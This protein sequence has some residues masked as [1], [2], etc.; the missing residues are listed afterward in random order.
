M[1]SRFSAANSNMKKLTIGMATFDDFEGV[2]FTIQSIRLNNLPRLDDLDLVVIDNN[3]DSA[4]GKETANFCGKANVRYF[5]ERE[6]RS[7]AIRDRVFRE[8]ESDFALCVDPH[9]LL[10]PGAIRR[11]I[12][13]AEEHPETSDLFH[14]PM[15]YDYL[16]EE[17]PATHMD[18]VWR[19]NMYGIWGHDKRGKEADADPFEIEMHGLGLFFC[20]VL[21]WQ[22]FSPLFRGFGGEEGYI[23]RKFRQ[24]GKT[25][26]LLPWL[27]WV[28]RFQRPRGISYPLLME[29]RIQNYFI[30]WE[31]L[32]QDPQEIHDHFA[33][34][35]PHIDRD[36]LQR[37]AKKLL[38]DLAKD[39]DETIRKRF[40]VVV[41]FKEK[42]TKVKEK[43]VR[44]KD[45]N[46]I[47]E[48]WN[49]TKVELGEA[50]S[51]NLPEDRLIVKSFEVSWSRRPLEEDDVSR[52]P[53]RGTCESSPPLG[54]RGD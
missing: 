19:D 51:I 14:G 16:G 34:T 3:P 22:G 21:A 26:L 12:E 20:R 28:H 44:K 47:V 11:L 6:R 1:N 48:L 13:F 43:E 54:P 4:E 36:R 10:E 52:G 25:V 49:T 39:R 33:K 41:P 17:T 7:T 40:E 24:A 31:E 53:V 15:L 46:K 8:A 37:E 23:H 27:R 18:P 9:V 35:F 38:D 45:P 5:E 42:E 30:G 32:G 2:F 29:E 50:L